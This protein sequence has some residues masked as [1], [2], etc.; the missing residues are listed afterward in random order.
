[1]TLVALTCPQ[2]GGP[3]PR[4]ALWRMVT[5]P[6]CLAV[7]TRS[8]DTVQRAAFSAALQRTEPAAASGDRVLAAGAARYALRRP[9]GS[10]SSADVFLGERLGPIGAWAT[11]KIARDEPG[12]VAL[13]REGRHLAALQALDG[14]GAAYF[15][16]RLPQ[17]IF[18]GVALVGGERREVL[19]LRQPTGYWGTVGD[20]IRAQPA[21][22]DPRHVVWMWRRVLETLAFVH[23]AGWSH[24]DIAP[25]H[26]LVDPDQHGIRLIGWAQAAFRSAD[27]PSLRGRDLRRLAWSMRAVLASA[28][29]DVPAIP[30]AT[31]APLATLLRSASEDDDWCAAHDAEAV[32]RALGEAAAASFGPPRFLHFDP[33]GGRS[34]PA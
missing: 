17:P 29:D 2:C 20:V 11:L 13:R 1:M 12:A 8:A 14:P 6:H 26:L 27:L 16:Q 19:V 10:G 3:L 33:L 34:T 30:A 9:L 4:Q 32:E 31:P 24:G 21:G 7:V 22:I 18:A 28:R 15:T 25:E 5:C 23:R